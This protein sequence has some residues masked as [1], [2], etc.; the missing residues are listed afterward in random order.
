MFQEGIAKLDAE[1]AG[2][3]RA[4]FVGVCQRRRME[5]HCEWPVLG[6]AMSAALGVAPAKQQSK[7]RGLMGVEGELAAHLVSK[8]GED[9]AGELHAAL[10][11]AVEL[12]RLE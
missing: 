12:S 11:S 8:L 4:D 7:I 10:W 9:D 5:T 6:V 2:A 1:H 3:A